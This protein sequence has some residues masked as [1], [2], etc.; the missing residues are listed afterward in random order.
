LKNLDKENE[1]NVLLKKMQDE[2]LVEQS[3]ITGMRRRKN[4]DIHDSY[5]S[6][7]D[8]PRKQLMEHHKKPTD[9]K[10]GMYL[11]ESSKTVLLR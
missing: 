11:V 5:I 6:F 9:Q 4:I 3:K 10:L 7:K 2:K 8:M 1:I